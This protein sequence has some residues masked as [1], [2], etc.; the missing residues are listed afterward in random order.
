MSLLWISHPVLEPI[1]QTEWFVT[2]FGV[3]FKAPVGREVDVE[4]VA[5]GQDILCV[6]VFELLYLLGCTG[7][8]YAGDGSRLFDLPSAVKEDHALPVLEFGTGSGEDEVV[9]GLG[10]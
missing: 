10:G 9:T 7:R 3:V 2:V 5:E 8:R 1:Q 4:S 6:E